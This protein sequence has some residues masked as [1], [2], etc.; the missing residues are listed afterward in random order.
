[1]STINNKN[2]E[3][4]TLSKKENLKVSIGNLQ[5]NVIVRKTL[6]AAEIFKKFPLPSK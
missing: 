5:E 6:R 3:K 4:V 2:S 1:M